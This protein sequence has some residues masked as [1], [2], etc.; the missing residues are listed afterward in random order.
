MAY[1]FKILDEVLDRE[2]VERIFDTT[3]RIDSRTY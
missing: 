2:Q 3:Q 1:H